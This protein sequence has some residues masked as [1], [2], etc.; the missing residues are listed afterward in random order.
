SQIQIF[1][2]LPPHVLSG[3]W[4]IAAQACAA[5]L[6]ATSRSQRRR[7]VGR[8]RALESAR[9]CFR[10]SGITEHGW[11]EARRSSSRIRT[12]LELSAGRSG[13]RYIRVRAAMP[14]HTNDPSPLASMASPAVPAS[15]FRARLLLVLLCVGWGTTWSTMRIALTEI[16]PFSMRVGTLFL[17]AV[18]LATLARLQGRTLK[19]RN[20]GAWLHLCVASLFNIVGFS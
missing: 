16:P 14:P 1:A 7:A 10:A 4:I 18:T 13:R 2:S 9:L 19:V 3:E 11:H 8:R 5:G 15:A 20:R 17:G 12:G 6:A